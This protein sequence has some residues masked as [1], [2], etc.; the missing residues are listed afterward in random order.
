MSGI[1][2][3]ELADVNRK[4]PIGRNKMEKLPTVEEVFDRVML[5]T[6]RNKKELAAYLEI[7]PS[8]LSSKLGHQWNLH[9]RIFIKLLPVM[10]KVKIIRCQEL[11]DIMSDNVETHTKAQASPKLRKSEE[12]LPK[13]GRRKRPIMSPLGSK[14]VFFPILTYSSNKRTMSPWALSC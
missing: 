5:A 2:K 1:L 4:M 12:N 6:N 3:C 8:I 11:N 13:N 14:S 10:V 9:W 7:D